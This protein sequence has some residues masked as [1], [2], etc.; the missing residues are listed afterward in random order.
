MQSLP[1]LLLTIILPCSL[2][3]QSPSVAK[4]RQE[5]YES[6]LTDNGSRWEKA[7]VLLEI[8]YLETQ[9]RQTLYE[10]TLGIYGLAGYY[11][12]HGQEAQAESFLDVAEENLDKM[13]DL[14]NNWPEA[15]AMMGA[16]LAIRMDF[17]RAKAIYLGPISSS[18]IEDG[19]ETGPNVPATWIEMGN[20]RYHA[21]SI[22][23]GDIDEA[24][25]CFQKAI[26]LFDA[27]PELRQHSW[28]YL[29]AYVWMGKAYEQK[30]QYQKAL[31]VFQEL[32]S[33]ESRFKVL[34]EEIMP[35]LQVKISNR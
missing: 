23:G 8:E 1:V 31:K 34:N 33:Y 35:S 14:N 24:I 10:W 9:N 12:A 20:L 5:I 17:N 30:G 4:A 18:H 32:Q 7:C 28:L 26:T 2:F 11:R 3:S 19:V 21:P 6:Y 15:H 16:V 22:F 25:R 13:L 29:H 27:H